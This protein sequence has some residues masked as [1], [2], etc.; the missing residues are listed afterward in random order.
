MFGYHL[1]PELAGDKINRLENVMT[2][3]VT[4]HI[5][6]DNLYLWLEEVKGKVSEAL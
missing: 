1:Q 6:F 4:I 3:S 2:L 5:L